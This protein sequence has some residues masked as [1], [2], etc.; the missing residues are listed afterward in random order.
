M[1]GSGAHLASSGCCYSPGPSGSEPLCFI[2]CLPSASSLQLMNRQL[3][4]TFSKS[5]GILKKHKRHGFE[6][7]HFRIPIMSL[8]MDGLFFFCLL[9]CFCWFCFRW[10]TVLLIFFPKL[11]RWE[12]FLTPF[13]CRVSSPPR[14][15]RE[16]GCSWMPARTHTY[17]TVFFCKGGGI[18]VGMKVL[19]GFRI[20]GFS[21][22]EWE[23]I[24]YLKNGGSNEPRKKNRPYFPLYWLFN[25]DTYFIVLL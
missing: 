22:L 12:P 3:C 21:I 14:R 8:G 18:F 20:T 2:G 7:I 17:H 11:S 24:K 16:G 1:S 6:K 23:K 9:A 15:Q 5:S 13:W 4:F 10:L 25:R 19:H